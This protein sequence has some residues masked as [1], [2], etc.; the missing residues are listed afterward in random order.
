M[1]E[2]H[3]EAGYFLPHP[4]TFIWRLVGIE[5]FPR[6]VAQLISDFRVLIRFA[7]YFINISGFAEQYFFRDFGVKNPECPSTFSESM[8]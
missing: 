5:G 7:D 3:G 8:Y 6:V 4:E 2:R 1:R